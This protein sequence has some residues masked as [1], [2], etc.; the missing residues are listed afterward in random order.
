MEKNFSLVQNFK[1]WHQKIDQVKFIYTE[2]IN[3]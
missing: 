3:E 1:P 2:K